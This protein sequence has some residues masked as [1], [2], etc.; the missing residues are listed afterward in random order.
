MH[1]HSGD[2]H[3]HCVSVPT[4]TVSTCS[5]TVVYDHSNRY[6]PSV[7]SLQRHQH[8][9]GIF[10]GK[11]RKRSY[12][13]P[14]PRAVIFLQNRFR[15]QKRCSCHLPLGEG[16]QSDFSDW[17]R[18]VRCHDMSHITGGPGRRPVSSFAS[19]SPCVCGEKQIVAALGALRTSYLG[20]PLAL[21]P[22]RNR[23]QGLRWYSCLRLV[24]DSLPL[25]GQSGT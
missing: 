18:P 2:V 13:K 16:G 9:T 17:V 24:C 15:S 11:I 10:D 6:W 8:R 25:Q 19:K 12:A 7:Y 4:C 1:R 22:E 20:P 5:R 3:R 21:R 14:L 23:D